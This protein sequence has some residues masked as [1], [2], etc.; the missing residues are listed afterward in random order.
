[1]QPNDLQHINEQIHK[2]PT[3]SEGTRQKI[4]QKKKTKYCN[5][6]SLVVMLLQLLHMLPQS[7][8]G[9]VKKE[10][11]Q[12]QQLL[13]CMCVYLICKAVAYVFLI[14]LLSYVFDNFIV[15]HELTISVASFRFLPATTCLVS[16]RLLDSAK[17][18]NISIK[19]PSSCAFW[20]L[21]WLLFAYIASCMHFDIPI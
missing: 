16:C 11:T 19:K 9:E 13:H 21:G 17:I 8:D 4:Q 5:T 6:Q 3:P 10:Q 15:D 1:M 7:T 20:L 14:S 2:K 18:I 12:H